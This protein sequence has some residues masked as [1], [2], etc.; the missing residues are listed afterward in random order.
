MHI[1]IIPGEDL[2]AED[3]YKSIF[4]IHQ[5][6][7]LRDAGNKV[8]FISFRI[9]ESFSGL[10]RKAGFSLSGQYKTLKNIFSFLSYNYNH[11]QKDTINDLPTYEWRGYYKIPGKIRNYRH[12]K[13]KAGVKAFEEYIKDHGKPEIIHAHSRFLIAGLIAEKIKGKYKIPYVL[14]EHSTFYARGLVTPT[15]VI[16]VRKMIN[17]ADKWITVSPQLGKVIEKAIPHLNKKWVYIPNVLDPILETIPVLKEGIPNNKVI[18]IT[19]GALEEKKGHALLLKAFAGAFK[20][21][22][23]VVLRIGGQGILRESLELLAKE[24]DI[25]KQVSFLGHISRNEI[26]D[27]LSESQVFV[28]PSLY[29]TF[30]VVLIEAL[31]C[32]LPIIATKCG[33]PESIVTPANGKL[34]PA[35]NIYA[36]TQTLL[37]FKSSYKN[38]NRVLLKGECLKNYRGSVIAKRLN[39]EYLLIIKKEYCPV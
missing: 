4:E 5:G 26:A 8:G 18:F 21:D 16:L 39:E 34:I 20:N 27:R 38:F 28:L 24:L 36:L 29:E 25:E 6:L 33:G 30:G 37:E 32:G 2:N 12:T 15:E 10:I 3:I 31:A 35:N 11:I 7:A 9:I 13:I 23:Q 1:L 14:T 17:N 22:D 19:I